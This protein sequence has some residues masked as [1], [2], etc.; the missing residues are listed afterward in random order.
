M[1][2]VIGL[3]AAGGQFIEQ[4]TK[5]IKLSIKVRDKY[6]DGPKEVASWQHQIESIQKVVENVLQSPSLRTND[7]KFT[8]DQ[9]KSASDSLLKVFEEIQ[10]DETD[11]FGQKT[12]RVALALSKEEEIRTLF[13][14][15]EQ[16]KSTLDIHIGIIHL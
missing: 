16:L 5:I 3:V 1:A 12:W 2:E 10:F 4:S 13:I 6:K 11:S 7:V 9:C 15:L 8:I 14:Q